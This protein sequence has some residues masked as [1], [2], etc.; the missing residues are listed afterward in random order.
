MKTNLMIATMLTAGMAM[1]QVVIPDGTLIRVRLGQNLSS[2]EVETGQTVDFRVTQEVRV[3]DAVVIAS[4]A[5][6]QGSIIS[7]EASRRMG[8]GGKLALT[9]ERVQ[10][11]DGQWLSVRYSPQKNEG[12]GHIA[13][14]AVLTG[15]IGVAFLPAAPLG[16]LK[17]GREATF[18][19]GKS[20]DVFADESAT[21]QGVAA[22][23]PVAV[24]ALPQSYVSPVRQ[25]N[26]GYANNGGQSAAANMPGAPAM[27]SNAAVMNTAGTQ[28]MMAG[29]GTVANLSV[30][31]NAPG[32]DIELDGMF[33]G[34]APTTVP[35]SAG[36]HKLVVK[37]GN[38]RWTRDINVTGGTVNIEADL[39]GPAPMHRAVAR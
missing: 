18:I 15:I 24:R 27:V 6:A 37:R 32:A 11:V 4:G 14:T 8:R 2:N 12:K 1:A 22:S 39:A 17:H 36:V 7:A 35:V 5:P 13:S 29:D 3:G 25:A 38:N 19:K 30:N 16:L 23:S 31:S 20:F 10:T 26:G 34:N 28:P 33:V 9:V 21:V